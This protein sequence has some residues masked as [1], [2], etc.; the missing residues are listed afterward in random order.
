MSAQNWR[1][2]AEA[3]RKERD[4]K[5]LIELIAELNRAL[6]ERSSH[7]RGDNSNNSLE[8]D[9]CSG[10]GDRRSRHRSRRAPRGC[11]S[12]SPADGPATLSGPFAQVFCH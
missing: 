1:D 8:D 11:V 10:D 5:R 12:K 3:A 4:P 2:L 6:D 9:L 7:S